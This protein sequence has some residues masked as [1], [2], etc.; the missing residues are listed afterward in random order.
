MNVE[1]RGP[2]GGSGPTQRPPSEWQKRP[3]GLGAEA[4]QG[5]MKTSRPT[6]RDLNPTVGPPGNYSSSIIDARPGVTAQ[7]ALAPIPGEVV[8]VLAQGVGGAIESHLV[9]GSFETT[10]PGNDDNVAGNGDYTGA[11]ATASGSASK[12][13]GSSVK[14]STGGKGMI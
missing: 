8:T 13:T 4:P 11:V 12:T 10:A 3:L 1:F 7:R 9:G 6:M 14:G 5:A 2:Q